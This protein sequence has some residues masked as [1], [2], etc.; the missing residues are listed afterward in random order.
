MYAIMEIMVRQA[1]ELEK[2]IKEQSSRQLPSDT[3]NDDIREIESIPLRLEDESSNPALDEDKNIMECDKMPLILEGELQEP[4]LVEK[5]E[6]A[7]D[8]KS[9]LKE[10]QVEK[11]HPEL[12]MENVLV[13]VKDFYF[14]I[15]SLTFGME[16]DQQVSYIE[17]PSIA[18]SQVWIDAQHGQMTLLVGKEKMKFD[19]H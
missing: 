16:N 2:V 9:S 13:G 3:K 15:E 19:L 5:N 17:R 11:Q 6:L 18:K 1:K 7:I 4:T 8:E 14:P 12:I 10:K